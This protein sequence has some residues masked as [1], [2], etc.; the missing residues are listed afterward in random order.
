MSIADTNN[1]GWLKI[2]SWQL[3]E[4]K[5]RRDLERFL[6]VSDAATHKKRQAIQTFLW[7]NIISIPL[8]DALAVELM[9]DGFDLSVQIEWRMRQKKAVEK[10][11]G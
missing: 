8:P 9:D 1:E 11:V 5:D 3:S 10:I 2:S 4:V 6:N 7:N